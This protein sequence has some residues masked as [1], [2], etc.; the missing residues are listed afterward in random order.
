MEGR[1]S[2]RLG[3]RLVLGCALI[4]LSC[5]LIIPAIASEPQHESSARVGVSLVVN[6]VVRGVTAEILSV[7]STPTLGT[8]ANAS[9]LRAWARFH[10]N[11]DLQEFGLRLSEKQSGVTIEQVKSSPSVYGKA[12]TLSDVKLSLT[13]DAILQNSAVV[14]L[15]CPH[16]T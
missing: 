2:L 4:L 15:L 8:K 6:R 16:S 11:L 14:L 9:A 12:F 13:R 5:W 7:R 1:D 3:K 10:S